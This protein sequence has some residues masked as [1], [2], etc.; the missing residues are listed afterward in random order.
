[1]QVRRAWYVLAALALPVLAEADDRV[2]APAPVV[3][4]TPALPDARALAKS[5]ALAGYC[6]KVDPAIAAK[7]Q[8]QTKRW[9]HS[10]SV[11]A[12]THVRNSDEYRKAHGAIAVFLDKVDE[13]NAKRTCSAYLPKGK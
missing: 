2:S 9:V 7:Y 1:M 5:D 12:V 6:A 4:P 3:A 8:E 13:R 11:A 10:T